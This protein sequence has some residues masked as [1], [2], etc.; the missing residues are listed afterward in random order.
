MKWT[1]WTAA[2]AVLG[3]QP[4]AAAPPASEEIAEAAQAMR[5]AADRIEADYVDAAAAPAIAARLRAEARTLGRRPRQ[6][7]AL[8]GEV[9]GLLREISRDAHFKFGYSADAMPAGAFD[10]PSGDAVA[11]AKVRTARINNF[12]VL[13]AERLPG[14]IGLIDFDQFTD[15][16]DMRR[17]LA[18]A[19]E[20][21][22]H[23][24]A[25][26]LDMRFNGG[27]HARGAALAISY[28]LP[29]TPQRLLLR[30]E[31]RDRGEAVEIRTEARL[32]A[33]RFLG[34]PVYVL[35]GPDTFS[36]AEMFAWTIQ[37][38]AKAVVVGTKTRG[39][40]HPSAR[41]RLT[42]H[43]GMILPTT[44]TSAAAG[45]SWEGVGVVPDISSPPADALVEA[46]R[47]ALA[48]LLAASP[49]D[50]FADNWR[51]LLAELPAAPASN[52]GSVQ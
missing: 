32:E 28:F 25:M 16:A 12:G 33:E 35:T 20:L 30:L 38:E 48:A 23:C 22:R 29:E 40:G 44:R 27:G 49:G 31:G 45:G 34:K 39:G 7:D 18:A 19:M 21:L 50:M 6:G 8:A 46:R 47:A 2:A 4:A 5:I 14:N 13:K 41:V 9:T 24:D 1:V 42:P 52:Q 15:P 51:K 11:A 17:P 10:P 36:A 43:Y 37:R 3:A 26:I